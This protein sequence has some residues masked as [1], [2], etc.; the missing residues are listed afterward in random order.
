MYDGSDSDEDGS[1]SAPK[2][3]VL[4]SQEMEK[5]ISSTG[6]SSLNR[7]RGLG[8]HRL[9][10]GANR[11]SR[12]W[13][14]WGWRVVCVVWP[15]PSALLMWEAEGGGGMLPDDGTGSLLAFSLACR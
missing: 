7:T 8:T 13:C 11:R 5:V 10:R 4:T 2:K 1:R 6:L 9:S 15:G 14:G 3:P 12:G